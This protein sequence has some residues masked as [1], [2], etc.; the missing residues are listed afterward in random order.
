MLKIGLTFSEGSGKVLKKNVEV[1]L[2]PLYCSSEKR[3]EVAGY[4]APQGRYLASNYIPRVLL[5]TP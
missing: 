1:G 4:S 5:S 2:E 3:G